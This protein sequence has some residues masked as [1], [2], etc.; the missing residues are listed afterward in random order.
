VIHP[1]WVGLYFNE[2]KNLIIIWVRRN[3]EVTR[4]TA[5]MPSQEAERL[6]EYWVGIKI[7]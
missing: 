3:S 1:C 2:R 4:D 5:G 7:H 6:L